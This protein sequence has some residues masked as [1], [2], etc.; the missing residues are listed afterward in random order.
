MVSFLFVVSSF[1]LVAISFKVYNTLPFKLEVESSIL[2]PY[3]CHFE[4][5]FVVISCSSTKQFS[6]ESSK[7]I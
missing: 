1:L 4:F 2:S 7:R 5:G 3:S 6:I